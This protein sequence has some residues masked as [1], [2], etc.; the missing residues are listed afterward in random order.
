MSWF[1]IN[2]KDFTKDRPRKKKTKSDQKI[3]SKKVKLP[4]NLKSDKMRWKY[5]CPRSCQQKPNG[6][7]GKRTF[8]GRI[9]YACKYER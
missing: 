3:T 4:T 9:C 6:N 8:D 2:A 1:G 7:R 5:H